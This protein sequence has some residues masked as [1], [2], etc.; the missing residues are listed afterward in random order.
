MYSK[1]EARRLLYGGGYE[2]ENQCT[3]QFERAIVH[4]IKPN[5]WRLRALARMHW[6]NYAGLNFGSLEKS[7]AVDPHQFFAGQNSMTKGGYEYLER[8]FK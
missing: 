8:N 1:D 2:G 3:A 5:R 4:G 6:R 7:R